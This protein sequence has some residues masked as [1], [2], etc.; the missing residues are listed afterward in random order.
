MTGV[1]PRRSST[2]NQDGGAGPWPAPCVLVGD[3]HV[4]ADNDWRTIEKPNEARTYQVHVGAKWYGV[5]AQAV[6]NDLRHCG[7][8]P[9]PAHR[10]MAKVCYTP[11]WDVE[12]II[13]VK[14]R[15]FIA[16]TLY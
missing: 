15:C 7:P 9:N 1:T 2:S 12:T 11:V 5:P 8:E 6:I 13:D 3:G 10:A 4:L 16:G 14:S